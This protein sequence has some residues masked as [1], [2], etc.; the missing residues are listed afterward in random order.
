MVLETVKE[1]GREVEK[2]PSGDTRV[3]PDAGAKARIHGQD[4]YVL[5][6]DHI[7]DP[8]LTAHQARHAEHISALELPHWSDVACRVHPHLCPAAHHHEHLVA[9]L[10]LTDDGLPAWEGLEFPHQRHDL[11]LRRAEA[12]K[13]ANRLMRVLPQLDMQQ[14]PQGD[15]WG[16]G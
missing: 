3:T 12:G 15:N 2:D 11:G 9:H 1:H 4:L 6:R 7:R 13:E 8:R 16:D 5:H 10:A 14:V